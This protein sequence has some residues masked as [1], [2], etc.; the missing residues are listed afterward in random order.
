MTEDCGEKLACTL[1][2]SDSL[3]VDI[4]FHPH[5][6]CCFLMLNFCLSIVSESSISVSCN[7]SSQF[8]KLHPFFFFIVKG[9]LL[10]T[11]DLVFETMNTFQLWWG[12][13]KKT[14]GP[15]WMLRPVLYN[16]KVRQTWLVIL[17]S[18]VNQMWPSFWSSSVK[19]ARFLDWL[20]MSSR[21]NMA[22]L[23][24]ALWLAENKG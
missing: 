10:W 12:Y 3:I 2:K 16:P 18:Q 8:N 7:F 23:S 22:E 4:F 19:L 9:K 21:V 5:P 20:N 14:Q 17:S 24:V 15:N 6:G 11:S 13:Q 1:K